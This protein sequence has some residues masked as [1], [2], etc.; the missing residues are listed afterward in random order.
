MPAN[1]KI[2]LKPSMSEIRNYLVANPINNINIKDIE[3]NIG[4]DSLTSINIENILY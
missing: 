3:K 4:Y 2:Q 1:L